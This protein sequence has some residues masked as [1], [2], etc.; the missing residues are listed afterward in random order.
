MACQPIRTERDLAANQQQGNSAPTHWPISSMEA[1][2]SSQSGESPLPSANQRFSGRSIPFWQPINKELPMMDQSG[3]EGSSQGPIGRE[4]ES[5]REP[6]SSK[7]AHQ[8]IGRGDTL[9]SPSGSQSAIKKPSQVANQQLGNP[10]KEPIRKQNPS[11]Q[12]MREDTLGPFTGSQS[13][14]KK[15]SQEA[16]QLPEDPSREPISNQETH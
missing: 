3:G 16:N 2:P 8:P 4:S 12:P 13:A 9:G 5:A 6:I 14:I 11:H 10:A 1:P 15:L 7:D